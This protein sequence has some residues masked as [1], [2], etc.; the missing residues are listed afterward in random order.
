MNLLDEIYLTNRWFA[1]RLAEMAPLGKPGNGIAWERMSELNDYAYF[2][3]LFGQLEDFIDR[4]YEEFVGP[5]EETTFMY[6]VNMLYDEGGEEQEII[7]HYY[8][9]R[10]EIAH[11]YAEPGKMK[12]KIHIADV[13]KRIEEILTF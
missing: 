3:L 1:D 9:L 12:G 13:Y 7:S 4:E 6:R 10:C 5:C 2:V 8:G 11:G